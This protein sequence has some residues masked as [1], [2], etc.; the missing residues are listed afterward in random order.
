M[1]SLQGE[2]YLASPYKR[3]LD[4]SVVT[5]FGGPALLLGSIAAVGLSVEMRRKPWF[6]QSRIGQEA[7]PF[8]VPKLVTLAGPI[9]NLPSYKGYDH[10]RASRIGKVVRKLHIDEGP[11]LLKVAQGDMSAV[12]GYRPL[13]EK[14]HLMVMDS[15]SPAEQSQYLQ[16][17]RIAKPAIVT[18]LSQHQHHDAV[19][20][21]YERAMSTIEYA[22]NASL[23]GD[24]QLLISAGLA[25]SKGSIE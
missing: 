5:V 20:D 4:V 3:A 25:V 16:A 1:N 13:V 8:N 2:E 22:H 7:K 24:L 6:V 14:D 11:Q 12:G 21:A 18:T 15:L 17:M 9:E 19:I 23:R 10:V